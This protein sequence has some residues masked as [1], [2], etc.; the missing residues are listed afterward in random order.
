MIGD[1]N[2]K[3]ISWFGNFDVSGW[4]ARECSVASILYSADFHVESAEIILDTR[5]WSSFDFDVTPDEFSSKVKADFPFVTINIVETTNPADYAEIYVH[6]TQVFERALSELGNDEKLLVNLSSGTPSM[7]AIWVLLASTVNDSQTDLLTVDRSGK[8]SKVNPA[9][10]FSIHADIIPKATNR[11]SRSLAANAPTPIPAALSD[12]MYGKEPRIK[13][14]LS[15]LAQM[16]MYPDVPILLIGR[17]GVGKEVF[18]SA[19]SKLTAASRGSTRT[20]SITA[21]DLITK[22]FSSTDS[23]DIFVPVNCGAIPKELFESELFGAVAGSHSSALHDREGLFHV[24]DGGVLFLDEI[25]ELPLNSQVKLLRALQEGKVRRV[26][27]TEEE[28][29][30]V[31][32]IAATNRDLREMVANGQFRLDLYYRLAVFEFNIP[33]L[34]ERSDEIVELASSILTNP[35]NEWA[36]NKVLSREVKR[37]LPTL[38][39]TGNIREL[40]ATLMRACILSGQNPEITTHDFDRA[41]MDPISHSATNDLS[42]QIPSNVPARIAELERSWMLA[43]LERTRGNASKARALIGL[44]KQQWITRAKNH[45][46][47]N[48]D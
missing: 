15:D 3:L 18:A 23:K 20:S 5:M 13:P 12:L 33:S 30:D 37:R 31:R 36:H 47:D 4:D 21:A 43:A 9:G 48:I 25:G 45:G 27:G 10:L 17:S 29:I 2:H 24:A 35:D 39:W 8:V 26:G 38:P 6:A 11:I 44:T 16:A 14:L 7:H 22:K 34:A 42:T 32:I 46:I 41:L 28:E 1:T 19:I 40:H